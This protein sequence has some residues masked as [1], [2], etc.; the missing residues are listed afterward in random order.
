MRAVP[1]ITDDSTLAGSGPLLGYT[2]VFALR[3]TERE[4]VLPGIPGDAS[5]LISAVIVSLPRKES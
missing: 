2:H 1:G 5:V 4:L 3:A